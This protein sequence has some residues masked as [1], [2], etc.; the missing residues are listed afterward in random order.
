MST[1]LS[2]HDMRDD[3]LR[4]AASH[5]ASRVRIFGSFARD[6]ACPDC[7]LDLLIDLDAGRDL[8][9]LVAIKLD[10]EELLGREVHVVTEAAISKYFRE[11]VVRDATPL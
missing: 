2:I 7:D 1:T 6:I 4:I 9:D 11:E 10:L 8:F 3:I 5:G